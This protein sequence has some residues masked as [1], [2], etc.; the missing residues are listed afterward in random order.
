MASAQGA[1]ASEIRRD[2]LPAA[3]YSP[4]FHK[5]EMERVWP[6]AW[7]VACREQEIPNV[8]DY[9][10]YEIGTESILVVR[11]A[12]D[13]IRAFYNVCPHR[14]R[15][16]RDDE[17]GSLR[18]F[19][20]GYHAWTFDLDGQVIAIPSR[21]DWAGCPATSDADLSMNPV[22]V[23][24]WAGWVWISMDPDAEPLERFL[25]PM[26]EKVDV[27]EWEN[28]RIRSYQTL[29]LPINWKVALEAFVEGY[30]S[31]G[32][33]PQLLKY[34][35]MY[36]PGTEDTLADP[37]P[38][39]ASHYGQ[40]RFELEN[41]DFRN[42]REYVASNMLELHE[43]LHGIIHEDGARAARRL[44]E[45]APEDLDLIEAYE[46]FG[47]LQ[48]EEALKS[49]AKWPERMV[50]TDLMITEWQIFPNC[51]VLPAAEGAFW[52]R[53]RPNGDDP[54]SCIFDI[55]SLGRYGP[56]MEPEWRH[57]VYR[58]L[59]DFKGRNP[60][61]EQDFSNMI[62]VHKGMKSRGWKG[63]RPNPLQESNVYNLHRGLHQYIYSDEK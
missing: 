28:C 30:H 25:S 17:R 33:H 43:T 58:D 53:S 37:G 52:Y 34:G 45:E 44:L 3:D 21:E 38:R 23:G 54:E 42:A 8:G 18:A 9:V 48:K 20:C 49:G 63:A 59:A 29:I 55:Y 27:F 10:N 26:R 15:R 39:H 19:F 6:R 2:F 13:R 56:G 4:D 11:A 35:E 41:L 50:G 57:E 5:L 51:S 36:L 60:I 47:A 31:V 14:G 62:A 12:P 40:F 32:T 61:L 1:N 7:Q 24:T 22:H 16:L 46:M